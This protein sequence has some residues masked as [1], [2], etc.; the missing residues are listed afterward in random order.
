MKYIT[1]FLAAIICT[2]V[3]YAQNRNITTEYPSQIFYGYNSDELKNLQNGGTLYVLLTGDPIFDDSLSSAV[4]QFWKVTPYKIVTLKDADALMADENNN[5][6]APS[7]GFDDKFTIGSPLKNKRISELT[8]FHGGKK[9]QHALGRCLFV[10]S[11]WLGANNQTYISEENGLG[12][13]I[14]A[15]NDELSIIITQ[16]IDKLS[17]FKSINAEPYPV[18]K[19][20][21]NKNVKILKD[22]VLLLDAAWG[23]FLFKEKS[24]KGYKYQYQYVEPSELLS[25]IKANPSKYCF[26]GYNPNSDI[27]IYDA[28][29]KTL[30][31][32]E[33]QKHSMSN[34]EQIEQLNDLISK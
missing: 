2:S 16:K 10:Y 22:K 3:L 7:T 27:E 32:S 12:Y 8:M 13:E 33:F 24:M 23:K 28:Q 4:K 15:L 9:K 31:Y 19:N 29:T 26:I 21:I 30:I 18:V 20:E 11:Y 17:N 6:L 25:L 1:T 5:F 34:S 14:K